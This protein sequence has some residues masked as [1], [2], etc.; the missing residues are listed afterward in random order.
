MNDD[1]NYLDN[2]NIEYIFLTLTR[3]VYKVGL[4]SII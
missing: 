1:R 3:V 4:K 2:M